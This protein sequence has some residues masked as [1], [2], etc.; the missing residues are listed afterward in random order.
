MRD[1]VVV[2]T[3]ALFGLALVLALAIGPRPWHRFRCRMRDRRDRLARPPVRG[4]NR[5]DVHRTIDDC[6][7]AGERVPPPG[8]R[9][10]RW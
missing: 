1:A 4:C 6:W 3:V 5:P 10:G 7:L 9:W 2:M 8:G